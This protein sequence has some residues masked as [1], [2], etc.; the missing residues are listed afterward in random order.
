[1]AL[2]FRGSAKRTAAGRRP[3][4]RTA[5]LLAV[6]ALLIVCWGSIFS[7]SAMPPAMVDSDSPTDIGAIVSKVRAVCKI[8]RD[9]LEAV[10]G[11]SLLIWGQEF[12][13]SVLFFQA[14]RTAGWPTIQHASDQMMKKYTQATSAVQNKVAG[15]QQAKDSIPRLTEHVKKVQG[16]LLDADHFAKEVAKDSDTWEARL[17]HAQSAIKNAKQ[18]AAA[19]SS[20]LSQKVDLAHQEMTKLAQKAAG[21]EAVKAKAMA[22]LEEIKDHLEDNMHDLLHTRELIPQI[23][24]HQKRVQSAFREAQK[25]AEM[26]VEH[27]QWSLR[28]DSTV[29]ALVEEQK[30]SAKRIAALEHSA[31]IAQR[32]VWSLASKKDEAEQVKEKA[33][34]ELREA[35]AELDEAIRATS[36]LRAAVTSIEP[37]HIGEC[38]RGVAQGAGACIASAA[39]PLMRSVCIGADLG[40]HGPGRLL[41]PIANKLTG[42]DLGI[43]SSSANWTRGVTSSVITAGAAY[44]AFQLQDVAI[45]VAA[46]ALGAQAVASSV[47]K[48][49]SGIANGT[50]NAALEGLLLTGGIATQ[51][52]M[53]AAK[54]G[55]AVGSRLPGPA[56]GVLAPLIAVEEWLT[57]TMAGV[58]AR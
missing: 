15:Y 28:H 47:S 48:R 25:L 58:W 1:M 13:S 42:A 39:S 35:Q 34:N 18:H 12:A 54:P 37:A 23:K 45:T 26:H 46:C 27:K 16:A 44:A 9:I 4:R 40:L 8:P 24:D 49:L 11:L 55:A 57:D 38:V 17:K 53:P 20:E 22:E 6:P 41:K 43:A 36:T 5:L 30:H 56:K 33:R 19:R 32:E 14:F 10:G 31:N 21:V 29:E 2:A 50:A 51:L 3:G 7:S 52:R